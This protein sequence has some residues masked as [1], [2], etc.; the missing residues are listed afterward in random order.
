MRHRLLSLPLIAALVL[1]A[2]AGCTNPFKPAQPERPTS[3]SFVLEDYSE[4]E[5]VLVT[6]TRAVSAQSFGGSTAYTN[7]LNAAFLATHD[8]QVVA[9][10][11]ADG[12][13]PPAEWTL[14]NER[15]FF[16]FL[17]SRRTE[18][19]DMEFYRDNTL[20]EDQGSIGA[21]SMALYRKYTVFTRDPNH[22]LVVKDT[23][24]LGIAKLT[25]V[26][27]GTQWSLTRW[28]DTFLPEIGVSDPRNL[29]LVSMGTRRL[30]SL[31]PR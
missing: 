21:G 17:I 11:I 16:D 22:D 26:L 28:E 4:P 10:A 18:P 14:T 13:T 31:A 25:V 27:D 1:A 6:I 12:V 8:P 9:R 3:G 7:S 23:L 19:Y 15:P 5:S 24:A 20:P 29:D 30:E 2:S